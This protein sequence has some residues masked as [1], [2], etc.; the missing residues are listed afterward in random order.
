MK[1]P[2]EILTLSENKWK[3]NF[4]CDLD[5][6]TE[7]KTHTQKNVRQLKNRAHINQKENEWNGKKNSEQKEKKL[8]DSLADRLCQSISITIRE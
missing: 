2:F 3:E 8:T 1:V 4:K 5:L 6:H 7:W